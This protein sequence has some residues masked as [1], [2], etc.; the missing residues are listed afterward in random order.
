MEWIVAHQLEIAVLTP[1][2]LGFLSRVLEE[3]PEDTPI[4]G[5]YKGVVGPII[6]AVL[7]AVKKG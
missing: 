2:A 3:L 5:K 6:K 4:V 7:R 1:I